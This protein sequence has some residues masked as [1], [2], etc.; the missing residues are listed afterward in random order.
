MLPEGHTPSGE[1][2][3]RALASPVRARLLETL[4]AR[5][6][7]DVR[8]L[9]AS[10]DRHPNTVRSH[11]DV[12]EHA[13]LVAHESGVPDGPGRPSVRYR[14][15]WGAD[16]AHATALLARVLADDAREAAV[17]RAAYT[18]GFQLAAEALGAASSPLD[19]VTAML[20]RLGFEPRVVHG[21]RPTIEMHRCAFHALTGPQRRIA[22]AA[23]RGL[24]A[25]AFEALG[26][27]LSLESLTTPDG[28]G[29][30]LAEVRPAVAP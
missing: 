20:D 10:T 29:P 13:G 6:P 11:L 5:G 12:L 7:S 30:C 2:R 19:D 23:H 15:L 4:R 28:P 14:A 9:A 3:H 22:C 1:Q 24:L 17:E 26:G 16:D 8:S 25:G 27:E 18:R 21:G